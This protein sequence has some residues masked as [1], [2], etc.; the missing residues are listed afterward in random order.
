MASENLSVSR[1]AY[2]HLDS[3]KD[4]LESQSGFKVHAT[5]MRTAS[6]GRVNYYDYEDSSILGYV[7]QFQYNPTLRLGHQY[8]I[9]VWQGDKIKKIMS[10]ENEIGCFCFHQKGPPPNA[11]D[12]LCF[13]ISSIGFCGD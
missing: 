9:V 2:Q 1:R 13:A 11:D 5:S 10:E 7:V 6:G 4:S 8:R 3:F 12:A